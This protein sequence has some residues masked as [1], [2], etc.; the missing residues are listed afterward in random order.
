LVPWGKSPVDRNKI[1]QSV[2]AGIVPRI[3]SMMPEAKM[4]KS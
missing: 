1:N 3:P 4:A 2:P